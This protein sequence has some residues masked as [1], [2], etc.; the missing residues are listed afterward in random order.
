METLKA[1]KTRRSVRKYKPEPISEDV[2]K[3]LLTAA[4]S[5]PS[6]GNQQPWKF[7]VIT[8]RGQ[9]DALAEMPPYKP[10][11][12][13]AQ[14]AV[15]VCVDKELSK[16]GDFWIIDCSIATQNLLLAAHSMG[17]GAVWLG[18][19]WL[20]DRLPGVVERL[21]LP[22]NIVPF[23]VVPIGVP[24]KPVKPQEHYQEARIHRDRW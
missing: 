5:G 2:T 9:L 17:L 21:E 13:S 11:F 8:D 10:T 19:Y 4:M 20:D 24:A 12:S 18:C 14:L 22:E 16:W 6:T 23:S 3:E 15:V 7:V 1:I